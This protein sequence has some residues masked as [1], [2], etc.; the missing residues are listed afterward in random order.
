MQIS[1][2]EFEKYII[3]LVRPSLKRYISDKW[4]SNILLSAS[5]LSLIAG[6]LLFYFIIEFAIII[7]PALVVVIIMIVGA[8]MIV[9]CSCILRMMS[10][11]SW[12]FEC[13]S[14]GEFPTIFI[15]F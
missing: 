13:N 14:E 15:P 9:L 7:F 10:M 12:I 8:A 1:T 6:T 2:N 4:R 5:V 11:N 3:T